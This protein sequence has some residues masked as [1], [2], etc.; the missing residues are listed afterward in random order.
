MKWIL[1][2]AAVIV[3]LVGVGVVLYRERTVER[4]VEIA[5]SPAEVWR[6][7]VDFAA[8]PQWNPFVIRAAA[9]D[10]LEVGRD[11]DVRIRNDGSETGFRPEVLAVEPERE[12]RWVGRVLVPGLLDGEH[13]FRLEATAGGTRFTQAERFRGVLVPVVGASIDVASG[14]DA[15][16][17]AL[18][19]R[20]L[21][22]I[23]R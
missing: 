23:A 8:Y 19:D 1:S 13:S 16:N 2:V 14:F 5:A 10:G 17:S 15:M 12:L 3:L 4:S 22:T 11:L 7:L 9:P 6:V 21:A 18:R 20:V